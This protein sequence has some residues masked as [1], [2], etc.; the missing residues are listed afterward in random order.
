MDNHTCAGHTWINCP[1]FVH[2]RFCA[3]AQQKSDRNLRQNS[4]RTSCFS[5]Q[6]KSTKWQE[7]QPF[8]GAVER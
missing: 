6:I 2:I 8:G 7:N 1:R 4:N 3:F 5:I